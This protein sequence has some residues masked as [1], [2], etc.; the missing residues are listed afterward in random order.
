M[1]LVVDSNVM[2]SFFKRDS[3]TAKIFEEMQLGLFSPEYALTE[4]KKHAAEIREKAGISSEEFDEQKKRLALLVEFVPEQ[5]YKGCLRQAGKIVQDKD[6]IDFMALALKLGIAMWSNDKS[7]K[8]QSRVI[9]L[10][11][12]EII[13]LIGF[14]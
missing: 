13:K 2:F 9:V 6:D 11:S 12:G 3:T 1:F 4:I 8:Q 7:L 10:D 14:R 5:E